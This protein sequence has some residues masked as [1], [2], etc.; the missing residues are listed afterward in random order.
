MK[1]RVSLTLAVSA[2]L[3]S[4]FFALANQATQ[5][6][7]TYDW[8]AF[9]ESLNK[10]PKYKLGVADAKTI[11]ARVADQ[12]IRLKVPVNN[13]W[14]GRASSAAKYGQQDVGSCTYINTAIQR[15]LLGAGFRQDQIFGVI[16]VGQ[17]SENSGVATKAEHAVRSVLWVNIEHIAPAI[18]IGNDVMVFDL[19]HHA[20]DTGS[21]TGIAASKWNGRSLM[22]WC[23]GLKDYPGFMFS[24]YD[25]PCSAPG[26]K[27]MHPQTLLEEIRENQYYQRYPA[28]KPKQPPANNPAKTELPKADQPP[29]VSHWAFVEAKAVPVDNPPN[30]RD[31]RRFYRTTAEG[32]DGSLIVTSEWNDINLK[33][34]SCKVEMTWNIV[35]P[36]KFLVPEQKFKVTGSVTISGETDR[37]SAGIH[38]HP[39]GFPAH[40]GH[41]S[42]IVLFSKDYYGKGDKF[43][44]E[45]KAPLKTSY[46]GGVMVLRFVAYAGGMGAVEYTYKWVEKK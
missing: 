40:V 25:M 35:P 20:Y 18:V 43:D 11:V 29:K 16:G 41:T 4:T 45:G 21:Y 38:W 9:G 44:F 24:M 34:H 27:P 26:Q 36:I 39:P 30:T 15:A 8:M 14:G 12:M 10:G 7:A 17:G 33:D 19:W 37:T 13:S 22:S 31:P 5:S 42:G 28:K 32:G 1:H 23:T 6:A 2:L 46:P 3:G